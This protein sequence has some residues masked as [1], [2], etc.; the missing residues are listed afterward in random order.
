MK[1]GAIVCKPKSPH[2][3]NCPITKY[4]LSYKKKDFEIKKKEKKIVNKFYLATL[5]KYNGK[6]LLIKNDRFK[7]LKNL[8]IF[9][10]KEIKKSNFISKYNNKLYFKMSNMNMNISINFLKTKKKLKNGIWISKKNLK[11]YMLP[12]FTKKIFS[13]FENN[14]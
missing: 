11:N 14:L 12:T 13:Y 8:L 1:L 4:C 9:P 6:I 2:C 10:M 3:E 7:F 5:Y